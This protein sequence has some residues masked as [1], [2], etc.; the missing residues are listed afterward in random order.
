MNI[1]RLQV[2]YQEYTPNCN[3]IVTE[4]RKKKKKEN[5][6]SYIRINQTYYNK[7]RYRVHQLATFAFVFTLKN[8]YAANECILESSRKPNF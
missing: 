7:P 4:K 2:Y 6:R 8:P 1:N 3:S 5:K